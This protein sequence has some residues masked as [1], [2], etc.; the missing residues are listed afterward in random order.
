[1]ANLPETLRFEDLSRP[2][3]RVVGGAVCFFRTVGRRAPRKGEWYASGAIPFAYRAKNDLVSEYLVVEPTHFAMP[4][5]GFIRGE[6]V[7][8]EGV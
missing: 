1:M 6:P 8:L 3:E 7:K 5:R 2:G 4:S